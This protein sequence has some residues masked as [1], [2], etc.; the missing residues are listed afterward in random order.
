LFGLA[1]I[2]IGPVVLSVT[3]VL[4]KFWSASRNAVR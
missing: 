1:G 3:A 4:L 2:F